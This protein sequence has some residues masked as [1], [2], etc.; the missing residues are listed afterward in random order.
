M[1]GCNVWCSRLVDCVWL[2]VSKLVFQFNSR[3]SLSNIFTDQSPELTI[4]CQHD[5]LTLYVLSGYKTEKLKCPVAWLGSFYISEDH[6]STP[7]HIRSIYSYN[8]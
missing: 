8:A 5:S 7:T 3:L 4:N 6:S 2:S 1:V